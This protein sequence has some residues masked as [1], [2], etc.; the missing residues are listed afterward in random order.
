[1]AARFSIALLA[2]G[3]AAW[4]QP[5]APRPNTYRSSGGTTAAR[6][7]IVSPEVH[8]DR[9][10]TFRVRAPQA[11]E[12]SLSL[13][14]TR[15]MSKDDSGLWS[16]AVTDFNIGHIAQLARLE[17]LDLGETN[18]S[19]RGVAELTRLKNWIIAKSCG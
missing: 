19:D 15:R 17:V 18:V 2:G 13:G 8:A 6:A 7:R 3:L 11:T 4:S 14:G 16:V 5:P 12:V 9:T 1:M 10:V